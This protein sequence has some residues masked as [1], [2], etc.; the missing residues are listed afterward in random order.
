MCQRG[1]VLVAAAE[2][3]ALPPPQRGEAL[4]Q[5]FIMMQVEQTN[6]AALIK[7]P[8]WVQQEM[9]PRPIAA[10]STA[11]PHT[12]NVMPILSPA[13][14]IREGG[15]D[16]EGG[17]EPRW[18]VALWAQNRQSRDA[19]LNIFTVDSP[20]SPPFA[21][22]TMKAGKNRERAKRGWREEEKRRDWHLSNSTKSCSN[23]RPPLGSRTAPNGSWAEEREKNGWI[24][25]EMKRMSW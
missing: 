4:P 24:Q 20:R 22:Q 13:D 21:S 18:S 23:K 1:L 6:A 15:S 25:R 2:F 8:T 5:G 17:V 3:K 14:S 16:G 11:L 12:L 9:S 7:S 10:W 19:C